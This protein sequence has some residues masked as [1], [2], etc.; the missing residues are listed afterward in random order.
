MQTARKLQPRGDPDNSVQK[1]NSIGALQDKLVVANIGEVALRPYLSAVCS[2]IGASMIHDHAL[3]TLDVNIDDIT[4]AAGPSMTIG[5]IVT[6][7]VINSLKQAFPG[8]RS[9]KI[10]VEYHARG[11]NW[12]LSV[13]DDG[14]GMPENPDEAK[15]G[16]GTSIVLALSEQLEAK[17]EIVDSNPGTKV[18]MAHTQALRLIDKDKANGVRAL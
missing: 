16:L 7:L 4:I 2:S 18:S 17:V 14:V 3:L 1:S 6:E 10:L 13:T 9:G 12:T 8:N 15:P 5:L 11:P